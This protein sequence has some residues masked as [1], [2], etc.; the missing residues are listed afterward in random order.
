MDKGITKDIVEWDLRNWSRAID[1]WTESNIFN[2]DLHGKKVL[3]IQLISEILQSSR[4]RHGA[5]T[6]RQIQQLL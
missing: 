6:G 2:N 1:F 3:D 4:Q 5:E